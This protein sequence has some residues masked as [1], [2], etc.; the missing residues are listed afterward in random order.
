MYKNKG[1]PG[2]FTVTLSGEKCPRLHL[3]ESNEIRALILLHKNEDTP[4]NNTFLERFYT[5]IPFAEDESE[6]KVLFT[7]SSPQWSA[8]HEAY[9]NCGFILLIGFSYSN[10]GLQFGKATGQLLSFRSRHLMEVP[11]LKKWK[12]DKQLKLQIWQ[13]LKTLETL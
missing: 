5:A 10:I 7:D 11:E 4:E 8:I 12:D 6:V 2:V 1:F 3:Q 9:P 13:Q